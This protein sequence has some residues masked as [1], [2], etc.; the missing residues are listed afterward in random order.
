MHTN[1][2][3]GEKFK[4]GDSGEQILA[5]ECDHH[6]RHETE[7]RKGLLE[8]AVKKRHEESVCARSEKGRREGEKLCAGWLNSW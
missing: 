3:K 5:S 8:R 4:D 7:D 1:H 6:Q 2:K